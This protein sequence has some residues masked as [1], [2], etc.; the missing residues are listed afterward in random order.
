MKFA[1]MVARRER[2]M[3][4]RFVACDLYVHAM[5]RLSWKLAL[6]RRWEHERPFEIQT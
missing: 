1:K 5:I 4:S 3:K 6:K 2:I